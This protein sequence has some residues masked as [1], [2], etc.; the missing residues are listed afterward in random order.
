MNGYIKITLANIIKNII[1]LFENKFKMNDIILTIF[2]KK[3]IN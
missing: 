2:F 1:I 3:I